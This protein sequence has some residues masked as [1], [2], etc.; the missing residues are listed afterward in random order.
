MDQLHISALNPEL[1]AIE[2]K[3]FRATVTLIWPYSSSTRQFALLLAEPDLRLRRKNGQVRARFSG[4]SA[5]G[6]ATT[7]VGIGDEVVLSLRGAQFI[8]EGA[9][10]TPGKSIDWELSYVQTVVVQVLRNEIEIANLELV[11]AAPT[12]ASQSPAR[13]QTVA[14]PSPTSAYSSPAFLKRARLSDGPFFQ[15]PYDPLVDEMEI[16]KGHDNK[17]R[18]KSYRD[19]KTYTF[20]A[21]TPSPEKEDVALGD[22]LDLPEASPSR[23]PKLPHTPVSP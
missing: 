3:H 7:G 10:S 4:A 18:R 1:S 11:D 23:A 13:R 14:A 17:R 22:E 5:K 16:E 8:Q 20:S 19:W 12:P 9:I 2:S 21:R 15:A 6:L